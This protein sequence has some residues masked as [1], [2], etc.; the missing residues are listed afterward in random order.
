MGKVRTGALLAAALLVPLAVSGC[1]PFS[2]GFYPFSMGVFTP[3]PVMPWA[4]E[5]ME[6]KY[7]HKND[8]RTVI[9]PP[10]LPGAPPPLCE[11]PPDWAMILRAM[12]HV[13]RGVP[14]I[15]EEFRDDIQIVTEL[16]KDT[17]D[18]PRFYPLVGP[19]QLHHCH[20]KCTIYYTETIESGYPFPFRCKRPRVE[21]V[22]IDKDHLH[23]YPCGGTEAQL[24]TF[25]DLAGP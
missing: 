6:E 18:P 23:L 25:R 22:Y 15:Y 1:T 19:A 16:I 4:T 2:P 21:V 7:C 17:I 20:W 11:D 24:S 13:T 8:Y 9:M 5:R 3:I 14:Y 10:I 12:P